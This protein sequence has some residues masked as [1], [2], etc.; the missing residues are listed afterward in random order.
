MQ[1]IAST[2]TYFMYGNTT[3]KPLCEGVP[4]NDPST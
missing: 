1:G 2:I 3:R 4:F